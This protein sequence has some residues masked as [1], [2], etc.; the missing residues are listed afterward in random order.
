MANRRE[1]SATSFSRRQFLKAVGG[2]IAA[3]GLSAH[4]AAQGAR[5][6]PPNTVL[7][8]SDD[9]RFDFM[10]LMEEA[11]A[12]LETPN[13]DRMAR[14]GTHLVNAFDDVVVFAEP[15]VDP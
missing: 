4:G 12:F 11:P 13:R 7:L 6:K 15:G 1:I 14:E 3:Y 2:G 10:G 8:V 9:H 5:A